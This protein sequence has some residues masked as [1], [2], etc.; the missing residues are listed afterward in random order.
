MDRDWLERQLALGRSIGD[1]ARDVRLHPSTVSYWTAK[2]GLQSRYVRVYAPRGGLDE[3][4]LRALVDRGLS[5]RQIAS[6]RSVSP[7]TVRHWMRRFGLRTE[8]ARRVVRGQAVRECPVHGLTTFRRV[9]GSGA[10]RCSFCASE[11]V[12]RRR[13]RTKEILVAEAGGKC[14]LCGY[15]RYVGALHFHHVDPAAKRLQ[16]GARGLTRALAIVRREAEK[17]VLLCANCHAEVEAGIV[18]AEA[19][20]GSAVGGPG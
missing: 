18:P 3:A 8:R 13:R 19:L 7:T 17:C 1:I 5:I 2:Y 11:R 9:G 10:F 4:D 20:C 14:A 15:H 16:I 6:A 12:S